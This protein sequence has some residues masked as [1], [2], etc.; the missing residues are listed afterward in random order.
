MFRLHCE[1]HADFV[2][3]DD[4]IVFNVVGRMWRVWSSVLQGVFVIAN[5]RHDAIDI[6]QDPERFVLQY[7]IDFVEAI[8]TR[9]RKLHAIREIRHPF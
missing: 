5:N 2:T 7:V 8:F 3:C 9:K 6:L 4:L 1:A